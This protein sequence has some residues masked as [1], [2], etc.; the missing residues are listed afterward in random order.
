MIGPMKNAFGL[1]LLFA[2]PL[3][4]S[5]GARSDGTQQVWQADIQIRTLEVTRTRSTITA[6][7]VV[8]TEKDDEARASRL[9]VLLPLGVGID[10]LGPGCAATAGP[11]M[12]PSLRAAVECDLGSIPDRGIREVI[13]T[14]TVPPDALMKRFGVFVY[15]NTPDPVP[16]NNYAERTIQ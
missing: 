7:I 4:A 5:S 2:L 11:S 10:K 1:T 13:L 14:T 16:G 8:Y 9:I 6:R 15:S 3:L 12:I